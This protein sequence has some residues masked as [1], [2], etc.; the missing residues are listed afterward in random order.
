MKTIPAYGTDAYRKY[1]VDKAAAEEDDALEYS[2]KCAQAQIDLKKK[3]GEGDS[4]L[5]LQLQLDN[6]IGAP[7]TNVDTYNDV[8]IYNV[9]KNI[10]SLVD[11]NKKAATLFKASASTASAVLTSPAASALVPESVKQREFMAEIKAVH[12]EIQYSKKLRENKYTVPKQIQREGESLVELA[13]IASER[14]ASLKE[15][16]DGKNAIYMI[17]TIK[18][19]E[20]EIGNLER[21]VQQRPAIQRTKELDLAKAVRPKENRPINGRDRE[22]VIPADMA[23]IM[24]V[25]GPLDDIDVYMRPRR[26]R[27]A[28]DTGI[29]RRKPERTPKT[30]YTN[31]RGEKYASP[32]KVVRRDATPADV[33]DY[34]E[35]SVLPTKTYGDEYRKLYG[36]RGDPLTKQLVQEQDD[37]DY[38]AIGK[39]R[40]KREQER[41]L[42]R[43]AKDIEA[44]KAREAGHEF[45]EGHGLRMPRM[46]DLSSSV[47][48]KR[49]K[50]ARVKRG[51]GI[52]ALKDFPIVPIF[53]DTRK[54]FELFGKCKISLDKLKLNV[55][56]V[57]YPNT[58]KQMMKNHAISDKLKSMFE[59]RDFDDSSL[60]EAE[61]EILSKFLIMAGVKKR[62]TP[63]SLVNRYDILLGEIE[64]GNNNP[65][66][67]K[68]IIV[69]INKL[70]R[71]GKLNK[72]DS[73][74]VIEKISA[75]FKI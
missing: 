55:L 25:G 50:N 30:L 29:G 3:Q 70:V 52:E 57:V 75:V 39:I 31:T 28:Q 56:C 45:K 38:E 7:Q 24:S 60:N 1:L 15:E 4:A 35:D 13:D 62:Q 54:E 64:C 11:T 36:Q 40:D 32:Q 12:D 37:A 68:D 33:G 23:P 59:T 42:A 53:V 71:A 61:K 72:E 2:I 21:W 18:A 26:E 41:A 74:D 58:G 14:L 9:A 47:V 10:K 22:V 6:K 17:K 46:V 43:K 27:P 48:A 65:E 69:V 66:L 16:D 8:D 63:N 67:L 19:L 49:M 5:L 51:R 20:E 34:Y 73:E 44:D